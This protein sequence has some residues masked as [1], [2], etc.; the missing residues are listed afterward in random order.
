MAESHLNQARRVAT[1]V[2]PLIIGRLRLRKDGRY[3]MRGQGRRSLEATAASWVIDGLDAEGHRIEDLWSPDYERSRRPEISTRPELAMSLDGMPAA[4][5]VTMFTTNAAS[6]AHARAVRIRDALKGKLRDL[7]EERSIHVFVVYDADHLLALSRRELES[8]TQAFVDATVQ[9]WKALPAE[10][11][12]A[13]VVAPLG[14]LRGATLTVRPASQFRPRADVTMFPPRGD[15]S[16]MV[17]MFIAERV[18]SKG[19]QMTPWGRSILVVVHGF[20]ETPA[21]LVAGFRRHGD[22]PWWRV[23]WVG[24]SPDHIQLVAG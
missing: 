9:A 20:R 15:L 13:E 4:L 7:I 3:D 22:V 21:D 6:A 5:D 8:Q 17:D 14:W 23:Y 1:D 10:A 2:A 12:R 19:R 11:D 18:L 24:P 16:H